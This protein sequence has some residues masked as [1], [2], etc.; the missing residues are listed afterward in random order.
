MKKVIVKILAVLVVLAIA[1]PSFAACSS[2][3]K[4]LMSI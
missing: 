1:I 4:K 3:G 2:K